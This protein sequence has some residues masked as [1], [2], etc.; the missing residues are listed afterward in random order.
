MKRIGTVI[1]T[2]LFVSTLTLGA[3]GT[4]DSA[5][6]NDG[7]LEGGEVCDLNDLDGQSCA[8]Q[9]F[10]S[11]ILGCNATCDGFNTSQCTTCGNAMAEGAEN[12]DGADLGGAS[13]TS[14]GFTG[15]TLG[16]TVSCTYDTSACTSDPVCGNGSVE[17]TEVCDGADLNGESCT[18]RGFTGGTLTCNSTCDGFNTSQCTGGTLQCVDVTQITPDYVPCDVA[19]QGACLCEGCVDDG[20][21]FDD[22]NEIA[23]DCVCADCHSDAFCTDPQYCDNDGVCNPYVEGCSCA[24]CQMHP[25][26]L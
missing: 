24:D 16:C 2:A 23:D 3:C 8:S 21:C 25:E 13:C 6:C 19:D 1:I 14:Q 20:V 22:T 18:T 7:I 5:V 26:C 17:G 9:G 15:G 4:S 12:C 11:G 10:T